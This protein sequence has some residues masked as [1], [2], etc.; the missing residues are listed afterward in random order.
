MEPRV[1]L[2]DQFLRSGDAVAQALAGEDVES[3]LGDVEPTGVLGREMDVEFVDDAFS[4][5]RLEDLIQRRLLV[6]LRLSTTKVMVSAS[7]KY[8][9]TR[10]RM[11]KAQSFLVWRSV[12]WI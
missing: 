12:T 8:L 3:D 11:K 9:S 2:L 1:D 4:L 6:V 5:L 10:S 7:G